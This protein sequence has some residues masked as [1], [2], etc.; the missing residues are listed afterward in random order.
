MKAYGD[1]WRHAGHGACPLVLG[2]STF[3]K[4]HSAAG[5]CSARCHDCAGGMGGGWCPR[6]LVGEGQIQGKRWKGWL[7]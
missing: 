1:E 2:P 5:T 3:C 6:G 4:R 7:S